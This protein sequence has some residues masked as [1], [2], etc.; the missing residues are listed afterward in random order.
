LSRVRSG[1]GSLISS[2]IWVGRVGSEFV[3]VESDRVQQIDRVQL[4]DHVRIDSFTTLSIVVAGAVDVDAADRGH[5]RSDQKVFLRRRGRRDAG[6]MAA[7]DRHDKFS[8]LGEENSLLDDERRDLAL[9][10]WGT[11]DDLGHRSEVRDVDY[12]YI[13]GNNVDD[14]DDELVRP[15]ACRINSM[16]RSGDEAPFCFGESARTW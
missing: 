8:S 1:H 4:C 5:D 3:W 9:R 16:H 10:D 15:K 12:D 13:F 2:R 7:V 14:D 11:D 6:A